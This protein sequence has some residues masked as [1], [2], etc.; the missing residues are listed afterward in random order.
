M[1]KLI[2]DMIVNDDFHRGEQGY[3]AV[4]QI[5]KQWQ[6]ISSQILKD[7]N[8]QAAKKYL[9]MEYINQC[10]KCSDNLLKEENEFEMTKMMYSSLLCEY[11]E[12]AYE[13]KI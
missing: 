9:N 13:G 4:T 12:N 11:L 3:G 1:Q 8:S 2:P 5:R 7:F 6:Q 10:M